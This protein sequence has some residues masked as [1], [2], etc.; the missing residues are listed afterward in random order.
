MV[1]PGSSRPTPGSVAQQ[2]QTT[3][4]PVGTRL[5]LGGREPIVVNAASGAVSAI[6]ADPDDQTVLFRQGAS[7]V[8]IANGRAWVVPAGQAGPRRLLGAAAG[9]LPS[10]AD[11][12]VWLVTVRFGVPTRWYRLVEVSLADGRVRTRWTLPLRAAP[13]AVLPS[14]VLIRTVDDDL[15]VVAP[16]SGRVRALLARAA[17]FIDAQAD[18]VAWLAGGDLHIRNLKTGV[19]LVVAP[20]DGS[21]GWDALGGPV[22]RAGCCYGL[23]ALAPDGRTLAIYARVAGPDTPGLA[24]V[25]LTRGRAALL[26]GSEGAT[27]D[28]RLPCLAWASNGW[29]Y[30]FASGPAVTSIGVWHPGDRAAGLLRLD[31]DQAIDIVPTTLAAN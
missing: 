28:G 9:V 25:D 22:R 1:P 29:L 14:G 18:R 10:L 24:V 2:R 26:A 20:P 17:T 21:A 4:A 16:G 6:T 12:R 13:V 3:S 23:G 15:Q 7:T 5:S 19:D 11:D 31:V 27:P 30:F 8:L